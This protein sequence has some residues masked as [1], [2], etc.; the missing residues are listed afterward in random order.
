MSEKTL[1]IAI[2][3]SFD[4]KGFDQT[5]EAAKKTEDQTKKSAQG[6]SSEYSAAFK[7]IGVAAAA[8]FA[9]VTAAI[10]YGVKEAAQ[11][12]QAM[13]RLKF[14]ATEAGASWDVFGGKAQASAE[15]LQRLTGIADDE[16]LNTLSRMI[17]IS[18]DAEGSLANLGLAA[19]VAAW[20]QIDFGSAA[21]I[22]AKAMQGQI[23]MLG[24][25]APE[26]VNH[27]AALG[28][29]VSAADKTRMMMEYLAKSQGAT[30]E[31]AKSAAVQYQVARREL[32]S[33]AESI[34]NVFLPAATRMLG[35]VKDNAK[36]F[37]EWAAANPELV[38][39][40]G[41]TL[42]S[43]TGFTAAVVG[44]VVV[45]PK[46][47]TGIAAIRVAMLAL[48]NDPRI[49]LITAAF[50]AIGGGV[51]YIL[52]AASSTA[53]LHSELVKLSAE[54][55]IS[56]E[57]LQQ[58]RNQISGLDGWNKKYEA[59]WQAQIA[60]LRAAKVPLAE[61]AAGLDTVGISAEASAKKVEFDAAAFL[62]LATAGYS[63]ADALAMVKA[64]TDKYV[65][66]TFDV[67]G[68]KPEMLG[69]EYDPMKV[70]ADNAA[71]EKELTERLK[72]EYEDRRNAFMDMT[73]SIQAASSQMI[74]TIFNQEMTGSQRIKMLWQGLATSVLQ[75]IARML[76]A[77]I[78]S[79]VAEKT[80]TI[81]AAAAG[82]AATVTAAAVETPIA[83]S[84]VGKWLAVAYAKELAFYGWT[85]PAA[86]GLAA[87]TIAAGIGAMAASS[88]TG[89]GLTLAM[90]EGG[91][92]P[93]FGS[94]DRVRLLAEPGEAVIP[95]NVV[96]RNY[97]Q[98][99]NL[100]EGRG[101]GNT[102]NV[103]VNAEK[104]LSYGDMLDIERLMEERLPRLL[105]R[106]ADQRSFRPGFSI[107]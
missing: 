86:P 49:L 96:Q 17:S 1:G 81:A 46:V 80:T 47:V 41:I 45:I 68:T 33:A 93:G 106:L 94:G 84:M 57:E 39:T 10:G 103:T 72:G 75:Q 48:A 95:K 90:Q 20:K 97:N 82:T 105:E 77:H 55:G 4:G 6:M 53:S 91:I 59:T 83:A 67:E 87:G 28:D 11:G 58:M 7:Q 2:K 32:E 78:A 51:A 61:A 88:A 27:I 21:D 98:V 92:V 42:L 74:G 18:G 63:V 14:S 8:G 37:G 62:R 79:K 70:A 102:F 107:G 60:T 50:A 101:G 12:E 54:L 73:S 30:E 5:Q 89:S 16:L 40:L 100:I 31:M 19:D 38:K 13:M 23:G 43:V 9:A 3:T 35:A 15:K 85:G 104:R 65:L 71:A 29:T 56:V 25:I 69:P 24:R 76:W 26:L 34:G 22:V 64:G 44:L 99:T 52:K 66:P 36:A